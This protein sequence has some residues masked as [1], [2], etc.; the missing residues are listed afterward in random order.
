MQRISKNINYI[1]RIDNEFEKA[2]VSLRDARKYVK[3]MS[4]AA[5]EEPITVQIIKQQIIETVMNSYVTRPAQV[6]T[7]SDLGDL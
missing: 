4:R 2:F 5:L 1:I 6:L 7:V 3:S